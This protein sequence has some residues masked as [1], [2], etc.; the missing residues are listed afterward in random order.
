[1]RTVYIQ[2]KTEDLDEDMDRIKTEFDAFV[3]GTTDE[4]GRGIPAVAAI[5]KQGI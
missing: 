5:L 1:M 2:R 3:D 4:L